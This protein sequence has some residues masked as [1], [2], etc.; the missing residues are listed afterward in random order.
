M[1]TSLRLHQEDNSM[2]ITVL[3]EVYDS[4]R[5]CQSFFGILSIVFVDID[6]IESINNLKL[7]QLSE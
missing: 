3:N 7:K 2:S 1:T 6:T 5:Y 4:F